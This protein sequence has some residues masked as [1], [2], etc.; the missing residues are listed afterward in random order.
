MSQRGRRRIA[1]ALAL[2]A[3]VGAGLAVHAFAPDSAASDIAGDVLYAAAVYAAIVVMVPRWTPLAVAS[4]AAA[5]G[6]AIELFQ[7]TGVPA[8]AGG[9]FAPATLVLGTV[10]DA[11]DLVI[12]VL[13]PLS[14]AALDILSS[15]SSDR[16]R[17]STDRAP[18]GPVAGGRR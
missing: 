3:V 12:A 8:L 18:R 6:S 10:F 5:W 1:A 15:P 4:V 9:V 11:R 14:A 17:P 2:A 7:L 16:R 13:V